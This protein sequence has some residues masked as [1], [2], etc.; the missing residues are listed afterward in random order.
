MP[1]GGVL[2]FAVPDVCGPYQNTEKHRVPASAA[3]FVE[4]HRSALAH[5]HSAGA[6]LRDGVQLHGAEAALSMATFV[7][8]LMP[9]MPHSVLPPSALER[10]LHATSPC[11]RE[12]LAHQP[13]EQLWRWSQHE[14]RK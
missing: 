2:F 14:V 8:D 9:S 7:L 12:R 11:P 1:A 4:D 5:G 13:F 10:T 3:H 6:L